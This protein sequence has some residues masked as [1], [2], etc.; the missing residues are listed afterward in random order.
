MLMQ[1][2]IPDA[3]CI[4]FIRSSIIFSTGVSC[5]L[6]L[7]IFDLCC[8]FVHSIMYSLVHFGIQNDLVKHT[9]AHSNLQYKQ[10]KTN[11]P[12]VTFSQ[13]CSQHPH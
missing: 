5:E 2:I 13:N 11:K 1:E 3:Y 9:L 4:A 6:C 7:F 8:P 12:D 10:F